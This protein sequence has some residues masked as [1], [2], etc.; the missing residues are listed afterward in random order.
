M[1]RYGEYHYTYECGRSGDFFANGFNMRAKDISLHI[2]P[3]HSNFPDIAARLA[4][5]KR[6]KS[7]WYIPSLD[8]VDDAAEK[9]LIRARLKVLP[10]SGLLSRR[11]LCERLHRHNA[12]VLQ[13]LPLHAV[14]VAEFRIEVI[15]QRRFTWCGPRRPR[16]QV[17]R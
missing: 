3:D 7:G 14:N 6:C 5:H 12:D 13:P 8:F 15:Q 17:F 10:P 16:D 11:K 1:I 2:P 9:D 4:P